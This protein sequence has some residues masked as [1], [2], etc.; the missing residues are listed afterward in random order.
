MKTKVIIEKYGNKRL[1]FEIDGK[2]EI[3]KTN[4][5]RKV[6][7]Q[8]EE[9]QKEPI[10]KDG[11]VIY[12]KF[13]NEMEY[14]SIFKDIDGAM[15]RTYCDKLLPNGTVWTLDASDCFLSHIDQIKEMRIAAEEQKKIL[16]DGLALLG[17]RWN[18]QEKVLEVIPKVGDL[19]IFWDY[20]KGNASVNILAFIKGSEFY[21]R[22]SCFYINCVKFVS[23]EQY[24]KIKSVK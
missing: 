18:E 21:I 22:E 10:P 5:E 3:T 9:K 12:V 19:C 15:L 4:G 24:R 1:V 13:N 8:F 11:D 20:D 2:V 23:E 14:I 16:F 17:K 6:T 7:I